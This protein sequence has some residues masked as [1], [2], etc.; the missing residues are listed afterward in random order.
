M[1]FFC[2]YREYGMTGGRGDG[3]AKDALRRR[4][5]VRAP[6]TV[7]SQKLARRRRPF[8]GVRARVAISRNRMRPNAMWYCS[9]CDL[10]SPERRQPAKTRWQVNGLHAHP[11][12]TCSFVARST[13]FQTSCQAAAS[14]QRGGHPVV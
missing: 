1:I 11:L 10:P 14:T 12:F 2:V 9:I 6:S 13:L 3:E 4:R 7:K 8:H 5:D